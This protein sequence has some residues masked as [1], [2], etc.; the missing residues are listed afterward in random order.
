MTAIQR[1]APHLVPTISASARSRSTIAAALLGASLLSL[2]GCWGDGDGA[3]AGAATYSVGGSVSGLGTNGLV[4][5]DGSETTS[6]PASTTSFTFPMALASGASFAVT[7]NAQPANAT[8]VVSGGSGIVGNASVDNISVTCQ[9]TGFTVGGSVTG[10]TRAGLVLANGTDTVA[11]ASGATGFTL[12]TAV[13]SGVTYAVTVL[14]QPTGEHCSLSRSAGTVGAANVGDVAV[15]CAVASHSLGGTI[16]GLPSAGLVLANGSDTVSPPAGALSFVFPTQVAEGGAYAVGVRSQP[17]DATCS[18]GSATGTMGTA[19]I[20]SV[21]VTCAA[22]AYHV[23]GTISGLTASGLILA[24][25]SDTV[26]P[27]ANV[28]TFA[29]GGTV[30]FGGS[31]SVAVLQQ[32]AGLNCSVAGTYPAAISAGDVTDIAVTCAPA[33]GLAI[34]AG[35]ASCPNSGPYPDGPAASALLPGV[36]AIVSDASGNLF[37][38]GDAAVRELSSAGVVTTIAGALGSAGAVD[39]SGSAARFAQPYGIV[40][41]HA[42]NLLATDGT[43]IR[44]VTPAGVVTT[45]AGS[46]TLGGYVDAT[47]SAARFSSAYGTALD[48]GGNL[49][50]ADAVNN[51]IRKITP[52]GV[53]STVAG[54]G[55]ADFVDG[56]GSAARFNLP[57]DVAL[58]SAGNLYVSDTGNHAV[59]KITP[60]GVVSTL[61]GGGPTLSGFVDGVGAAA[62]L[63]TPERLALGTGG[64]LYVSDQSFSGASYANGEA[65]RVIDTATGSVT[66]LAVQSGFAA[67]HPGP[68]PTS[69]S[70]VLPYGTILGGIGTNAQGQLFLGIG[71]SVQRVG[72]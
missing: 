47:G 70:V 38:G 18:V 51:A 34:V 55:S 16:S 3:T 52:A 2:A 67:S 56:T 69:A 44:R 43:R 32:P 27:A 40:V 42:S 71:C 15:V 60:A 61:A 6:I 9:P 5:G 14:S 46:L 7:V 30:A 62:R 65:V 10:L 26:S 12:P 59:R 72:P 13:G 39:G 48:S 22:N 64:Q 17:T 25:G 37:F 28:T 1:P 19:D 4:L 53:V 50:V 29:F 63:R 35:Q 31:Y 49:Y 57:I 45:L 68:I 24:N 33:S 58:D 21:Q 8:C 36:V 54:N 66:T 20:A 41:D 11:I 23:G